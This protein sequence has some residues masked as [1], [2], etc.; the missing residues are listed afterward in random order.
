MM[1]ARHP[2]EVGGQAYAVAI[3]VSAGYRIGLVEQTIADLAC[4]M[5]PQAVELGT[6]H[7]ELLDRVSRWRSL[8]SLV[9]RKSETSPRRPWM[10]Q[11]LPSFA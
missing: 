4:E 2:S 11:P 10:S 8:C 7:L 6:Q 1:S 5:G 9:F 3:G